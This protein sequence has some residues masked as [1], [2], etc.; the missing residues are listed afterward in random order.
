VW[1]D[2]NKVYNCTLRIFAKPNDILLL[3]DIIGFTSPKS[4]YINAYSSVQTYTGPQNNDGE[5][6][7]E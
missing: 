3:M 5:I 4:N 7:V 1:A 6:Q 2:N